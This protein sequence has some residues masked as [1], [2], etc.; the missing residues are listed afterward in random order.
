MRASEEGGKQSL[1]SREEK[2][3]EPE[4]SGLETGKM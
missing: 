2:E 3:V 1:G 4:P